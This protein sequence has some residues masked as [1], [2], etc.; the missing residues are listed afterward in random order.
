MHQNKL[1]ILSS[2][3][4]WLDLRVL[5][6]P[7]KLVD[8]RVLMGKERGSEP[9]QKCLC[10]QGKFTLSFLK[11]AG[12]LQNV[13]IR[14]GMWHRAR[15]QKGTAD[16]EQSSNSAGA[17]RTTGEPGDMVLALMLAAVYFSSG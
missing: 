3:R 2:S 4:N 13:P 12:L 17:Q 9:D 7:K 8:P 15:S 10:Q 11:L 1:L 5:V 6:T 14:K 16:L